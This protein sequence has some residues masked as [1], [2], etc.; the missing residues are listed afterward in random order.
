MDPTEK[1]LIIFFAAIVWVFLFI[2][3]Y[4]FLHRSASLFLIL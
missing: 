3:L 4:A 1:G 2:G